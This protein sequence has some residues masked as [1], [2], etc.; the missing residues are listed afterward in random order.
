[1]CWSLVMYDLT[2]GEYPQSAWVVTWPSWEY[3]RTFPD[4]WPTYPKTLV[5]FSVW[6]L[7]FLRRMQIL[8]FSNLCARMDPLSYILHQLSLIGVYMLPQLCTGTHIGSYFFL[9]LRLF[10]TVPCM[11]ELALKSWNTGT[12]FLFFSSSS[13]QHRRDKPR[14]PFQNPYSRSLIAYAPPLS[15]VL[16]QNT[17]LEKKKKIVC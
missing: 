9:F 5:T 13:Q 15:P 6:H 12:F 10:Q 1:M 14:W 17:H 2:F 11:G 4:S 16:L 8:T 7:T 3:T